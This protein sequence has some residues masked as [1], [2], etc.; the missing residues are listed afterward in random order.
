[1]NLIIDVTNWQE[2]QYKNYNLINMK[3]KYITFI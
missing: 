2:K 3:I 1:M